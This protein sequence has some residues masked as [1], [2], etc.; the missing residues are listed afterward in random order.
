MDC[1]KACCGK[2]DEDYDKVAQEPQV[3][4]LLD[5]LEGRTPVVALYHTNYALWVSTA[6]FASGLL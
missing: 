4:L 6:C 3:Q 5:G 2:S 1:K